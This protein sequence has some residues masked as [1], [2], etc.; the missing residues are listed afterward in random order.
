MNGRLFDDIT[1]CIGNTPLVRLR[2]VTAG[3][4]ATVAGKMENTNP[5]WN[6]KDRVAIA[7]IEA[8]ERDGLIKKDT[9]KCGSV[10]H[11]ACDTPCEGSAYTHGVCVDDKT[12]ETSAITVQCCCC[13]EG[14]NH[15]SFIGG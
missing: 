2:R 10:Q 15:R 7:M 4:V 13:T 3:C 11:Y 12:G 14:A 5:L 1:Q 6:L 9:V 8:A